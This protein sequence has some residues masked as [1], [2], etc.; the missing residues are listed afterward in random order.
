M[1]MRRLL[2]TVAAT[3]LFLSPAAPAWAAGRV[4]AGVTSVSIAIGFP[5]KGAPGYRTPVH[6]SLTRHAAV[7]EVV[8]ATDALPVARRHVMCPMIMRLGPLLSVTFRSSSGAQLAVATVNVA[9][10]SRGDSGASF[11]F[12]IHF[13]STSGSAALLG[14]GWVRLMG[15]LAGTTIS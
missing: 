5:Q 9:Y 11:C 10:G 15:R 1:S 2:A 8:Q 6:R 14:N 7:A 12:P 3:A 4:P 13:V